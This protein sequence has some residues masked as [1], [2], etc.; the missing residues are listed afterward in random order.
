[1]H[2]AGTMYERLARKIQR[3]TFRYK[4]TSKFQVKVQQFYREYDRATTDAPPPSRSTP[5]THTFTRT[6]WV[7]VHLAW[8]AHR[9]GVVRSTEFAAAPFFGF[10]SGEGEEKDGKVLASSEA[11]LIVILSFLRTVR[12]GSSAPLS[13]FVSL[14]FTGIFNFPRE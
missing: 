3:K 5:M 14:S 1:M 9:R 8:L 10:G 2:F 13:Y 12:E 11:S 6:Q 7:T 4:A